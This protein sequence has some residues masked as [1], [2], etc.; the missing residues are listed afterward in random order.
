MGLNAMVLVFRMLNFKPAFSLSSLIF[1]KRLF[2]Y[3]SLSAICG[4]IWISEVVDISFDNLDFSFWLIQLGVIWSVLIF[5]SKCLLSSQC[6]ANGVYMNYVSTGM[7]TCL[8]GLRFQR[9]KLRNVKEWNKGIQINVIITNMIWSLVLRNHFLP[10][11]LTYLRHTD[12]ISWFL[13]ASNS[14]S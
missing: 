14:S 1:I 9:I 13:Q 12:L 11:F 6:L 3:S 8:F 10:L 7:F 2:N 4:F 5:F